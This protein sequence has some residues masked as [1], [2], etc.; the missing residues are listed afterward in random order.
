MAKRSPKDAFTGVE[1]SAS[2][3]K[4][5]VW[6]ALPNSLE[7]VSFHEFGKRFRRTGTTVRKVVG[8]FQGKQ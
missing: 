8:V 1:W 6:Q 4:G 7:K 5:V 2:L 3:K